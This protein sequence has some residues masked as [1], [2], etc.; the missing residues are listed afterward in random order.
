MR[1]MEILAR[2]WG[3]GLEEVRCEIHVWHGE[4]DTSAPVAMA[5]YMR[6]TIPDCRLTLLP[7]EGH[8]LLF[9]RWREILGALVS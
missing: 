4:L 8:F 6:R 9:P 2:P 1:E 7:G 5:E 3:F